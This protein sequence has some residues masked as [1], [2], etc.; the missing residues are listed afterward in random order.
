MMREGSGGYV[1]NFKSKNKNFHFVGSFGGGGVWGG[2]LACDQY[3]ILIYKSLYINFL[4]T[5][6]SATI[7]N[8]FESLQHQIS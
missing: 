2:G 7:T 1:Q 6:L 3:Q 4:D 5:C 8:K